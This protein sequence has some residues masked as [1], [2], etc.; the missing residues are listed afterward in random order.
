V[1]TLDPALEEALRGTAPKPNGVAMPDDAFFE[2]N[3]PQKAGPWTWVG[4]E[5]IFFGEARP[6]RW[7]VKDLGIAPGRPTLLSGASGGAKTI[8]AQS[9][10][11]SLATGRPIWGRFMRG[12]EVQPIKC[13]H[14]DVDLGL[15]DVIF[16][17][18]RL[19]AGFPGP[20][21][22][23]A[24]LRDNIKLVSFPSPRIDLRQESARDRLRKELAGVEFCVMD[25]LRGLAS[26]NE[27][28]SEFRFAVD[29]LTAVSGDI[30]VT[31]FLLH[32]L[33]QTKFVNGKPAEDDDDS[34]GRGTTG[35]RD[36]AG[37]AF[38]ITGSR[39]KGRRLR[40]VKPPGRMGVDWGER[41]YDV[42]VDDV[43][44]DL[45]DGEALP[46]RVIVAPEHTKSKE[47]IADEAARHTARK[48]AQVAETC[49]TIVRQQGD[50]GFRG[51]VDK[52]LRTVRDALKGQGISFHNDDGRL[53]VNEL[54]DD[55]KLFTTGK[56]PATR[57]TIQPTNESLPLEAE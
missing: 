31:F 22:H 37:A 43:D 34:A 6:A 20:E 15:D 57:I 13:A 46:L 39:K 45:V 5:E 42:S 51:G 29:T 4:G 50:A 1:T 18:R 10:V 3:S 16:R 19:R 27:N 33:G 17:Y 41:K 12:A 44:G 28:D 11:L 40:M 49:V 32:H 21:L 30:G 24:L 8:I 35:I 38:K 2:A 26:G 14:V 36:G 48:D 53:L 7:V 47:E 23:G 25:A 54:F 56:G 9:L 55:K 52:L